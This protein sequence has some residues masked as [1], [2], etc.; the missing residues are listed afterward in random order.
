MYIVILY[1][2]GQDQDP[3]PGPEADQLDDPHHDHL[4]D[5]DPEVARDQGLDL[6]L[7]VGLLLDQMRKLL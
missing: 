7:E 5:H 3:D 2:T 6:D 1:C 4:P